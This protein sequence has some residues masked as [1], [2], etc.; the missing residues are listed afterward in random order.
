MTHPTE[1]IIEGREKMKLALK[2][3]KWYTDGKMTFL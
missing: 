3:K 2:N 1:S